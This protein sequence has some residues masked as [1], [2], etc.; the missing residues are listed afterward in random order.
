M[1][2]KS[3]VIDVRGVEWNYYNC[4]CQHCCNFFLRE[5]KQLL[6]GIICPQCKTVLKMVIPLWI[7][8]GY[9]PKENKFIQEATV[10]TK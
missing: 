4:Q 2:G 7:T 5:E 10:L 3:N 6:K 9:M 1:K 8:D